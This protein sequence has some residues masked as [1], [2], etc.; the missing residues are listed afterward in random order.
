MKTILAITFYFI[1]LQGMGQTTI[2]ICSPRLI[3][4]ITTISTK[5]GTIHT[6]MFT[7][8]V[9]YKYPSTLKGVTNIKESINTWANCYHGKWYSLAPYI[10]KFHPERNT[11]DL[12]KGDTLVYIDT[13]QNLAIFM[14]VKN[15]R[16][17]KPQLDS[18]IKN[19]KNQ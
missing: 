4:K 14:S 16:K 18:N 5:H 2:P 1:V 8:Q 13:V 19:L 7:T 15:M 9:T 17:I 10:Y 3:N 6:Y 12:Y 11:Y